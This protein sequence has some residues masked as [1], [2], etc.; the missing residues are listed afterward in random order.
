MS[1]ITF[2]N[3]KENTEYNV[4]FACGNAYPGEV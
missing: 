1:N 4:Y 3:L 2:S